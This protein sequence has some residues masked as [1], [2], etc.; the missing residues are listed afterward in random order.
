MAVKGASKVRRTDTDQDWLDSAAWDELANENA[1]ALFIVHETG[2]PM[3][4][5][6]GH[7]EA[8]RATVCILSGARAGKVYTD[9][10]IFRSGIVGKLQ[11]AGQEIVG[12][13]GWYKSKWGPRVGVDAEKD[14]DVALAEDALAKLNVQGNGSAQKTKAKAKA[15]NPAVLTAEDTQDEPPF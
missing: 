15:Q 13:V 1:A 2:V 7:T 11:E 6:L 10:L 5:N 12:R 9:E 4:T 8:V 3:E 14:G